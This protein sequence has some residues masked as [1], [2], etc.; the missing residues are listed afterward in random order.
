VG[1]DGFEGLAIAAL[2]GAMVP[3]A[4]TGGDSDA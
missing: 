4:S 3:R 1:K 2:H